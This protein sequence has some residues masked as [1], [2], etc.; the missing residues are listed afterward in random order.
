MPTLETYRKQAKLLLRWHREGDYSIGGRVRQ[1][2]RYRS[3]TDREVLDLRFT[4]TLAQ[5]IVALEAGH[6]SWAELKAAAAGARKSPRK[7][8]S[9]PLLKNVVP[10]LFVRNVGESATFFREKLGFSIE[11]LHGSPPFYGAVSR[12]GVCLHLRLVH[13]PFFAQAA[14]R[15]KS[16][17]LASIEVANVQGLFDEFKARGVDFAQKLKKQAWGGTDFHVR[18]PDGNVIS[19]VTYNTEEP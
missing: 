1:L 13:Q 6:R 5:E 14:A 4:L 9:P 18:D 2:Q 11:F 8:P 7:L 3:L 16:L 17:I 10:I 15:E 19:F 12:D